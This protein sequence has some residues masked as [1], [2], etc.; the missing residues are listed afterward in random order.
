MAD[1]TLFSVRGPVLEYVGDTD[2]GPW[3]WVCKIPDLFRASHPLGYLRVKTKGSCGVRAGPSQPRE[4][5]VRARRAI[6]TP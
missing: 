4:H 1:G 3:L 6:E 2:P 5:I